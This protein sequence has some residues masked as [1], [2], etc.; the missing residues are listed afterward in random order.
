MCIIM[1]SITLLDGI[2]NSEVYYNR[3]IVHC[4]NAAL[5]THIH[6]THR[7]LYDNYLTTLPFGIFSQQAQ[8]T[9]L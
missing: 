8:L 3:C 2:S 5:Y 9:T 4:M 1:I 7:L 6:Y